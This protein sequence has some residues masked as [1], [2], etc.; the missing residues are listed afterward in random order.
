[1]FP[2]SDLTDRNRASYVYVGGTTEIGSS[3]ECATGGAIIRRVAFAC[4]PAQS[5]GTKRGGRQKVGN[6]GYDEGTTPTIQPWAA[7][8]SCEK[9][10][11]RVSRKVFRIPA[12][13]LVHLGGEIDLKGFGFLPSGAEALL[14]YGWSGTTVSR[15]L[16]DSFFIMRR[17]P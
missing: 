1:M 13:V 8:V 11:G 12:S 5:R 14:F 3:G 17:C 4:Q 16:P 2:G 6:S 15:A 10:E 7:N 9:N